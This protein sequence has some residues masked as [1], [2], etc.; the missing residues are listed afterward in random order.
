MSVSK[1]GQGEYFPLQVSLFSLYQA[2]SVGQEP[3]H[4]MCQREKK[5]KERRAR[6][7]HWDCTQRKGQGSEALMQGTA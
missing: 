7:S 5:R 1:T 4:G 3:A 2:Y 6:H